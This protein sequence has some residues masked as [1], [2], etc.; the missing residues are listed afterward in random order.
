MKNALG[1]FNGS[2]SK[3]AYRTLTFSMLA[4]AFPQLRSARF[5]E[6]SWFYVLIFFYKLT[7]IQFSIRCSCYHASMCA[8]SL[9]DMT[10][11]LAKLID[12]L[13][14]TR[15]YV[16]ELGT[17]FSISNKICMHKNVCGF[18]IKALAF[19]RYSKT[20][21]QTQLHYVVL[22]VSIHHLHHLNI[23]SLVVYL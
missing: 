20:V 16:K 7:T 13:N 5:Q 23:P 18:N 15:C 21:I 17:Y 2:V 10:S 11:V 14:V 8:Q 1:I 9:E 22:M 6:P 3:C 4:S 19:S 12:Q